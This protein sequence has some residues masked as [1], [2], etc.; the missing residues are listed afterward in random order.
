MTNQ[1]FII[2]ESGDKILL[3]ETLIKWSKLI[4]DMLK[5]EEDY[6]EDAEIPLS[7]K[8]NTIKRCIEFCRQYD[9]G[10]FTI[11]KKQL[12]S[13]EDINHILPRWCVNLISI[14]PSEILDLVNFANFID[15]DILINVC[16]VK[17]ASLMKGEDP[18]Q[19]V[20]IL[21]IRTA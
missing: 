1:I 5:E 6:S 4:N 19:I 17:L 9:I 12:K 13:K 8:T 3:D 7:F 15:I 11:P 18:K 16:C 21:N 10:P 20:A 2:S 14:E